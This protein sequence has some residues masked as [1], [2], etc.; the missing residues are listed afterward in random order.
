MI[1]TPKT[2]AVRAS[3]IHIVQKH[4]S[5]CRPYAERESCLLIDEEQRT[6]FRFQQVV[7]LYCHGVRSLCHLGYSNK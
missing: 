7:G 5:I 4:L 6:I 2:A 1:G 3:A